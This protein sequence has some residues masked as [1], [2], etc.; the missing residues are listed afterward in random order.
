MFNAAEEGA[1]LS[2]E[3]GPSKKARLPVSEV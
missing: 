2:L 1:Y 3:F